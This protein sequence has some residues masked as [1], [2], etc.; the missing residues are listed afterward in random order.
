M[1]NLSHSDENYVSASSFK[2]NIG[3]KL[4]NGPCI[5][6]SN[7]K[8]TLSTLGILTVNGKKQPNEGIVLNS[9]RSIRKLDI[10]SL[11]DFNVGLS[12][13]LKIYNIKPLLSDGLNS[14][15]GE[16][17]LLGN[18]IYIEPIYDVLK[19]D[20]GKHDI[21]CPANVFEVQPFKIDVENNISFSTQVF[22]NTPINIKNLSL[23]SISESKTAEKGIL[24]GKTTNKFRKKDLGT[25]NS[26][27]VGLSSVRICGLIAVATS[28]I[29]CKIGKRCL[30]GNSIYSI[31]PKTLLYLGVVNFSH[32]DE[33]YVSVDKLKIDIENR[34]FNET[35]VIMSN[36][37]LNLSVLGTLNIN[38]EKQS[39]DGIVLSSRNSIRK[40][41]RGSLTSFN[42]C[43]SN[44]L[45]IYSTKPFSISRKSYKLGLKHLLGNSL[46]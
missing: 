44:K 41:N 13:K 26:N 21:I 27:N 23:L 22:C 17:L 1:S 4:L 25:I 30:L 35:C 16:R 11:V 12:N 5:I 10:G 8:L 24:L 15:L 45:K 40:L 20:L 29:R 2:I 37:K 36:S 33:N 38:G 7:S 9:T 19:I 18:K 42:I 46:I 32:S 6:M 31:I 14:P 3:T 28:Y 39:N 43:L 34:L